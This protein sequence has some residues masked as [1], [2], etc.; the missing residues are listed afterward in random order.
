[1]YILTF[2]C[3]ANFLY[4][5]ISQTLSNKFFRNEK[6]YERF[7]ISPFKIIQKQKYPTRVYTNAIY[8]FAIF[9]TKNYLSPL[10]HL[11]YATALCTLLPPP[12]PWYPTRCI[13]ESRSDYLGIV[14]ADHRNKR[15]KSPRRLSFSPHPVPPSQKCARGKEGEG[16]LASAS[17]GSERNCLTSG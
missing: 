12:H 16:N 7:S 13:S 1:M 9:I 11:T 6:L 8:E 3:F 17:S 15:I 14:I 2:R 4:S 5:S 10:R